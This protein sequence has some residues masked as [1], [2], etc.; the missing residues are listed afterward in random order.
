MDIY[1]L[2]LYIASHHAEKPTYQRRETMTQEQ[3]RFMRKETNFALRKNGGYI[4]SSLGGR[5]VSMDR[6]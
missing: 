4:P 2:I 6:Q 1:F 3:E 5:L